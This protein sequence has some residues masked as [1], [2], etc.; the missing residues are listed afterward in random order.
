MKIIREFLNLI[1]K[2]NLKGCNVKDDFYLELL[3]KGS[4]FYK[5]KNKAEF[6]SVDEMIEC[7]HECTSLR[8]DKMFDKD[9]KDHVDS[10]KDFIFQCAYWLKVK[11]LDQHNNLLLFKH[12]SLVDPKMRTSKLSFTTLLE[13]FRNVFSEHN[14]LMESM[15]IRQEFSSYSTFDFDSA[16]LGLPVDQFWYKLTTDDWRKKNQ[17]QQS[18][19]NLASFMLKLCIL[20]HSTAEVERNFSMMNDIKTRKRH[21]LKPE[22]LNALLLIKSHFTVETLLQ[23]EPMKEVDEKAKLFQ[24]GYK[25][26]ESSNE[27]NE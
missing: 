5:T 3:A 10:M 23:W 14:F 12:L 7:L 13:S 11:C 2:D 22:F 26:S 1:L 16:L 9:L 6:I 15:K 17:H 19:K 27:E 18:F 24:S 21:N 25:D 8:I 4:S 20:P